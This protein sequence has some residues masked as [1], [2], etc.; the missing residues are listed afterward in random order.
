MAVNLFVQLG[1][2]T[3]TYTPSTWEV[4]AGHPGDQGKPLLR[5]EFS[6][7]TWVY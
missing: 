1:I 7:P 2:V 5:S 6:R 3:H 4:E